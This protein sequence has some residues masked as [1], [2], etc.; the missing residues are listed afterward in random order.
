VA[1][2]NNVIW[3]KG[4]DEIVGFTLNCDQTFGPIKSGQLDLQDDCQTTGAL[5]SKLL[6]RLS[7][8]DAG[9]CAN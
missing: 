7:A 8:V 5:V 6:S 4:H 3:V 1:K 2:Y 9:K